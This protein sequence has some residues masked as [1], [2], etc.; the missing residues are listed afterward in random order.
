[1]RDWL[2][3]RCSACL[4]LLARRRP[5][6]VALAWAVFSA[7]ATAQSINDQFNLRCELTIMS[8]DD[9]TT[10]EVRVYAIDLT[11]GRWSRLEPGAEVNQ[12]KEVTDSMIVLRDSGSA[13][14]A[15]TVWQIERYTGKF[16]GLVRSSPTAGKAEMGECTKQ[17][18]TGLP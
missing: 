3:L 14:G 13:G 5:A 8:K 6:T 9:P 12:L 4:H 16:H 10:H 7:A 11:G 17:P 15:S 1:M 2:W 18:F